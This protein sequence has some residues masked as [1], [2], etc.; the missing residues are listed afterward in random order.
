MAKVTMNELIALQNAIVYLDGQPGA[1]GAAPKIEKAKM[2]PTVRMFFKHVLGILAP[3]MKAYSDEL[4]ERAQEISDGKPVFTPEQQFEANKI[5]VELRAVEIEIRLPKK[6]RPS[7]DLN[8]EENQIPASI[9]QAL[10]LVVQFPVEELEPGSDS[11]FAAAFKAV[12]NQ[13]ALAKKKS[14]KKAA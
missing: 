14:D 1:N 6:K 4:Q 2:K 10:D 8:L 11:D 3:A 12:R 5:D 13:A 7:E 9:L